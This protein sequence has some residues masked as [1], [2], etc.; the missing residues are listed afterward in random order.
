MSGLAQPRDAVEGRE[1]AV[2]AA[3]LTE[4]RLFTLR[5]ETVE[6][7]T[8]L[9]AL[10]D[11]APLDQAAALEAVED[12]VERGDVELQRAAGSAIDQ[13]GQLVAVAVA[14]LEQRHD[15]HLGAAFA[16]LAVG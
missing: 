9:A 2:P 5:G 4:E 1:E 6:T 7:P 11:P 13:L 15:Q 8:P 12:R 10:L 14:L 3:A 16:Q